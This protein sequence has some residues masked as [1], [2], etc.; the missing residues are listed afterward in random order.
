M[1]PVYEGPIE[2]LLRSDA[3]TQEHYIE[4][5]VKL[6]VHDQRFKM[7]ENK[8]NWIISLLVGGMI[9]PLFFHFMIG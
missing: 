4:H 3:M 1:K 8:L 7:I 9:V 2:G 5:E 6:R